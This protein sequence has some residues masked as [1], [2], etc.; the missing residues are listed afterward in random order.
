MTAL[1]EFLDRGSLPFVGREGELERIVGFWRG[2]LHGDEMR[3]LVVEGEAGVGKSRLVAEAADRIAAERG[4]VVHAKLYAEL[5][6]AIAPLLFEA[7][8]RT[9]LGRQIARADEGLAAAAAVLRRLARLRPTIL[10]I[11]DIHL[12]AG[13]PVRELVQLLEAIEDEPVAVMLTARTQDHSARRVLERWPLET[14]TLGV[15]EPAEIAALWSRLFGAGSG[16]DAVAQLADATLGNPLALRS[17]LRGVLRKEALRRDDRGEWR[18]EPSFAVVAERGATSLVEGML[19]AFTDA[20]RAAAASLAALGEVFSREA[21]DHMLDAATIERLVAGGLLHELSTLK[22]PLPGL[23]RS[24]SLPYAYAHSLVHRAVADDAEPEVARLVELVAEAAPLHSIEP[25]AHIAAAAERPAVDL[26][27][28]RAAIDVALAVALELDKTSDWALAMTAHRAAARLF[29]LSEQSWT[30]DERRERAL[31]I[32]ARTLA[33][34]RRQMTSDEYGE[35]LDR[36]EALLEDLP[37]ELAWHR[38]TASIA[39][40]RRRYLLAGYAAGRAVYDDVRAIVAERPE[41]RV[42]QQYVLVLQSFAQF[43]AENDDTSM[44]REIEREYRELMDDR[45][46]DASHRTL[47]RT[48]VP[49]YLL[50]LFESAEELD[51]RERM[52]AELKELERDPSPMARLLVHAMLPSEPAYLARTGRIDELVALVDGRLELLRAQ[53]MLVVHFYFRLY[54]LWADVLLGADADEILGRLRTLAG[55]LR[56]PGAA[57]GGASDIARLVSAALIRGDVELAGAIVSEHAIDAATLPTGAA[58]L[59]GLAERFSLD[60]AFAGLAEPL[61]EID[62]L[63]ALRARLEALREASLTSQLTNQQVNRARTALTR[64]LEWLEARRLD[65]IL[66]SLLDAFGD[67]LAAK[68]LASWRKRAASIASAREAERAPAAESARLRI[69]ML[70]RIEIRRPGETEPVQPRG[71]RQKSFL[72]AMVA[73]EVLARPLERDEFLE[74]AGIERSDDPKLARDAVNSAIYRLRDVIGHDS[75]LTDEDTPRLNMDL[76]DVDLVDAVR[77]V[78]GAEDALRRGSLALA[79]RSM[80][81]ALEI[82]R[83]DVPFPALYETFFEAM[84]EDVETRLRAATLAVA[85]RLLAERD[86]GGAEAILERAFGST[87]DD[88]EI[89]ELY[90]ESLESQGRRTE[91]ERVRRRIEAEAG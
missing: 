15:L 17:A 13:A 28:T 6:T 81:E 10:I 86:A 43:A 79:S 40:A 76:I 68:D 65:V 74:A 20:D 49:P 77:R 32:A 69:S 34:M 35:A 21:A 70:G 36:Y 52:Y 82:M 56:G 75:L 72:G 53:G 90:C 63:V 19:V 61:I 85:R 66:R 64:A 25:F 39:L 5:T 12:L 29:E 67:R 9:D 3:V 89:A 41:L 4:T 38:L 2:A 78:R 42:H 57:H 91:A 50:T 71:A 1:D 7:L 88:E 58:P 11:E 62:G 22:S 24:A 44:R 87:P 54:R 27:V 14:L 26:D 30:A 48:Q 73:R 84:R 83:G 31:A 33:L 80:L 23:R 37:P 46:I 47:A 8:E 18:A 55:E 16:S 60:E 51:E 45:R 59:L